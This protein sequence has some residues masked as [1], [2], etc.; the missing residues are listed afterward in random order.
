MEKI[1]TSRGEWGQVISRIKLEYRHLRA[2]LKNIVKRI[3]GHLEDL[4]DCAK[5]GDTPNR[6][7][8]EA[9]LGN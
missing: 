1:Y 9:N 5:K 2:D 7:Y 8:S 6:P 4:I 3:N